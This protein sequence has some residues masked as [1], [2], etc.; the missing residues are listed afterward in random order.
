[1]DSGVT[2]VIILV[3]VLIALVLTW[4]VAAFCYRFATV[5]KG[6]TPVLLR[7]LPAASGTGWRHGVILYGDLTLRYFRLSSVRI[8]ADA[9]FSRH[10][11]EIVGRRDPV[12]S[13]REIM[14]ERVTVIEVS[15]SGHLFELALDRG[16]LTALQSWIESRPPERTV[17]PSRP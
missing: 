2:I 6:G 5:R 8:F 9:Q 4:L 17:R 15:C 13:E 1:M 14:P 10:H 3:F 16:S 12:A 7:R 11:L